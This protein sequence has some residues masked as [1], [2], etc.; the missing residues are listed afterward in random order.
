MKN[1][2]ILNI[3][4]DISE[5]FD[6]F[7]TDFKEKEEKNIDI[8]FLLDNDVFN[9]ALFP[10]KNIKYVDLFVNL[11]ENEKDLTI[12]AQQLALGIR[13][14]AQ[15][16]GLFV[17]P[18]YHLEY[19]KTI[20][21][22]Y[23]ELEKLKEE[24][25]EDE[26]KIKLEKEKLLKKL[27]EFKE[28]YNNDSDKFME[29]IHQF[30][31]ILFRFLNL[32]T[33]Y[34]FA[35]KQLY[36]L[37]ISNKGIRGF[38]EISEEN[39]NYAEYFKS[40]FDI[41]K[42]IETESINKKKGFSLDN[43]VKALKTVL[44]F[45]RYHK[46]KKLI[47]ITGDN[48]VLQAYKKVRENSDI[49]DRG[50]VR[51]P[52]YFIPFITQV[53]VPLYGKHNKEMLNEI[54]NLF[55]LFF[56]N[57]TNNNVI[58]DKIIT[59]ES[60]KLI[61]SLKNI[62][63]T[64]YVKE[65]DNNRIKDAILKFMLKKE[66]ENEIDKYYNN[67]VTQLKK[68]LSLLPAT[69]EILSVQTELNKIRFFHRYPFIIDFHNEERQKLF[70]KFIK[71]IYEHK[72]INKEFILEINENMPLFA[73]ELITTII[74]VYANKIEMAKNYLNLAKE[75]LEKNINDSKNKYFMCE[76]KLLN[77][78]I[79]R[80]NFSDRE[81]YENTKRKYEEFI[82]PQNECK[83]EKKQII[84]AKMC[85]IALKISYLY[86]SYFNK[87][88]DVNLNE[89]SKNIFNELIYIK[90]EI[91]K[92]DFNNLNQIYKRIEIQIYVNIANIYL[93]RKLFLK[94]DVDDIKEFIENNMQKYKK[95]L[96][97]NRGIGIRAVILNMLFWDFD[98]D[99]RALEI[100]TEIRKSYDKL[101]NYEKKRIDYFLRIL[102]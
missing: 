97:E 92:I 72:H 89:E 58:N 41:R 19:K 91:E 43:D 7:E 83:P 73:I 26:E 46:N 8:Y 32:M 45:N 28:I 69:Y 63:N 6:A 51:Y 50:L 95:L 20:L 27:S 10:K 16:G 79:E 24:L 93:L 48:G 44:G 66:F 56:K 76:I 101:L 59:D 30:A 47:L 88:K 65:L 60:K 77:M 84:R 102:N 80:T 62:L 85:F 4:E 53:N 36:H 42:I 11:Y 96:K 1:G 13:Y 90:N 68:S 5:S 67:I 12:R 38:Q 70:R 18:S 61:E 17:L 55:E 71:G 9:L 3:I 75:E 86:D 35:A 31:P 2:E 100:I 87:L 52:K 29:K 57:I 22:F 94:E 14:L 49:D 98:K 33:E 40:N 37:V 25:K 64:R 81:S 99:N 54:K 39:V 23:M 78:F 21:Y 82:N 34:S 74:M 15:R